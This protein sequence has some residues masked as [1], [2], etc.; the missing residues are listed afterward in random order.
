VRSPPPYTPT[1]SPLPE[2]T[3]CVYISAQATGLNILEQSRV[4]L[5]KREVF[6]AAN[7]LGLPPPSDH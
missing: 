2:I 3:D 7:W 1:T 4:P 5:N 6:L